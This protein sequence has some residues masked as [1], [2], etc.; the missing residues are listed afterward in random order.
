MKSIKLTTPI[1][2]YNAG[3]VVIMEDRIAKHFIAKGWGE[4]TRDEVTEKPKVEKPKGRKVIS[5][6]IPKG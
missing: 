5:S 4:E 2:Y 6:K 3:E 1:A